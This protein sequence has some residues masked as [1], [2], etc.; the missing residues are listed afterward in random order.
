M[1]SQIKNVDYI[2]VESELEALL[3]EANL[4]KKYQPKFNV[5]WKDGKAYPFIKITIA[6]K[7]PRVTTARRREK[8]GAKYFGPY[9]NIKKMY[10]ILR[11]LR[12]MFPY[13]SCRLLPFLPCL[14]Y[15]LH[16]CPAPCFLEVK[17]YRKTIRHLIF[18]LEGKK[19][20]ILLNLKGEMKKAGE[21]EDFEKASEIKKQIEKIEYLALIRQPGEYLINPNLLADK[22]QK[23]ID[24]LRQLLMA[25]FPF[26]ISNLSRIEGYDVSNISGS[27]AT[28]A[29]VVL[30]N[31][32]EDKGQYRKFK[33][34]FKKTPDDVAMIKEVLERRLKHPEWP[35]PDLIVIDGGKGQVSGALKVLREK[36][37]LIPCLGL[38]K[39]LEE[40][41]FPQ[42]KILHLGRDSSAFHLLQRI[43]DEAHR[44]ALAYHRKLRRLTET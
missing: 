7:Y 34:K 22:R 44:F 42:G 23:E 28:G 9:P 8:N 26:L 18:F 5:D 24:D 31:G 10:S 2:L 3:L 15:H 21:R 13:R 32:E 33:I 14:Y 19:R 29:M 37:V 40:V 4:I 6:E 20:R 17:D 30:T 36:K 35:L 25:N 1:V 12:R 16:L 38:A 39:R 41:V 11:L 43:R 27:L